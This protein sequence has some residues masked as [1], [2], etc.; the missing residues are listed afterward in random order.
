MGDV[1]ELVEP[2]SVNAEGE[3]GDDRLFSTNFVFAT[4]ANFFNSIG[5]QMMN[6]TV[7][8]YVLSIGGSTAEAGL[9]SGAVSITALVFRSL[10]GWV[11][12][13]WRRRPMVLVGTSCYG[14]ASVIY[15]VSG[16]IGTVFF[17]R[18]VHGFGLS[19]YSTASNS[20]VADIAPSKQRAQAIGLF[21]AT[22]SLGLILG[23]AIG[24]YIIAQSGFHWLFNL[25]TALALVAFTVSIF[26]EEK[27]GAQKRSRSSWS[28]RRDILAV[29]A[30]PIA[31]TGLCLGMS[32]GSVTAFI[33]IFAASR[34][35]ENPGLYFTVQ[36]VM[37]LLSRAFSGRL[38]DKYGRAFAIIPGSI[39]MAVA[40]A[41]LPFAT[42]WPHLMISAV[43]MG[44]GFGTAQP[45]TM[46]LLVDRV[47]SDQR[48]L[49]F[50]TYSMGYDGGNFL[51]ATVS[52]VIS[53]LWGFGIMWPLVAGWVLLGLF[54]ILGASRTRVAVPDG[55]SH[56]EIRFLK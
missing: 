55:K 39:F 18:V 33:A 44:L 52:G 7:P 31:W 6:A 24:F 9:I 53:Q 17:G 43:L 27:R 42:D 45:A 56:R 32:N 12:D 5:V 29:D 50:A 36:A 11:T 8:V 41:L 3:P 10:V 28:W 21:A 16:S 4:L 26:A 30:L 37:L 34:G 48:G 38:A 22:T 25:A 46:A 49:A 47:R 2:L 40:L 51:G 13:V 35:I 54:G 1:Q 19:C 14:I 23:P 20:Y 15:A